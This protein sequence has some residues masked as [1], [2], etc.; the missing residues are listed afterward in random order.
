MEEGWGRGSSPRGEFWGRRG[1]DGGGGGNRAVRKEGPIWRSA[2]C[3]S[4]FSQSRAEVKRNGDVFL[5]VLMNRVLRTSRSFWDR[6]AKGSPEHPLSLESMR[7]S[8]L[9]RFRRKPADKRKCSCF[10][11]LRFSYLQAGFIF[12]PPLLAFPLGCMF[13]SARVRSTF[14]SSH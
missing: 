14:V 11:L 5:N 13:A 3:C 6:Y 10:R 4:C 1:S 12:G 9:Q 8:R 2:V 7:A